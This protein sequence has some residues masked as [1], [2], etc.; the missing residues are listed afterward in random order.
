MG[1]L[2]FLL[3]SR[4]L[5]LF[6]FSCFHSLQNFWFPP[7]TVINIILQPNFSISS[8]AFYPPT[9]PVCGT[10]VLSKHWSI[11]MNI[12]W[13]CSYNIS[14]KITLDTPVSIY[15][16]KVNNRN[17]RSIVNLEHVIAIWDCLPYLSLGHKLSPDIFHF[18][19]V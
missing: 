9:S 6:V 17:T 11:S 14:I 5:P 16:L 8:K 7:N 13:T 1:F 2:A 10:K 15:L 12:L 18:P 4:Y 3:A 19:K